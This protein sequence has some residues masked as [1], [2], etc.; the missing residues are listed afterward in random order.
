M[1]TSEKA[2]MMSNDN[3]SLGCEERAK[4]EETEEQ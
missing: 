2:N 3:G 4:E 1:R